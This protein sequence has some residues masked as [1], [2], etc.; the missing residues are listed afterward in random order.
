MNYRNTGSIKSRMTGSLSKAFRV[1]KWHNYLGL[2]FKDSILIRRNLGFLVFQFLIPV[3]QI[4]LFC[5]CIGREPYNLKFGIVNNETIY[6]Q[7]NRNGSLMFIDELSNHTFD[8]VYLNWS[9]AYAM[10]KRGELW[11]FI[12][13]SANFTQATQNKFTFF[14]SSNDT[15]VNLYLDSS[16]KFESLSRQHFKIYKT[17]YF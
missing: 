12:D 11:G 17:L 13:L 3:I 14:T 5:L 15:N 10:T 1:P 7:T 9:E 16:S 8:K 6:N 4:S 2:L